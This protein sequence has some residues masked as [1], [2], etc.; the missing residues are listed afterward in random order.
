M[1]TLACVNGQVLSSY[2][3]SRM[4]AEHRHGHP[5]VRKHLDAIA[6]LEEHGPKYKHHDHEV[7]AK[8]LLGFLND[9]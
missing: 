8:R 2:V 1:F 4:V 7:L 9:N 5:D 3:I 6:A